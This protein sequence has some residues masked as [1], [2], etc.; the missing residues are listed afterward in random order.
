MPPKTDSS[1]TFIHRAWTSSIGQGVGYCRRVTGVHPF[2]KLPQHPL[3][4]KMKWGEF[5]ESNP[6]LLRSIYIVLPVLFYSWEFVSNLDLRLKE[7]LLKK[8]ATKNTTTRGRASEHANRCAQTL[9]RESLVIH[10][11]DHRAG[12]GHPRAHAI[13]HVPSHRQRHQPVSAR[14]AAERRR[15][16]VE[17]GHRPVA[18]LELL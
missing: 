2:R 16:L 17:R 3:F 5:R 6:M 11:V 13:W 12:L 15:N 8:K 9:R 7:P 18:K 10:N 4:L 1:R 14:Q